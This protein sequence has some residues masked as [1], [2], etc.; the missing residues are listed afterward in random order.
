[1]LRPQTWYLALAAILVLIVPFFGIGSL[2][3][4]V[5]L[6]LSLVAMVVA[7]PLYG[8]RKLQA[9]VCLLSMACLVVWSILLGINASTETLK[10]YHALPLFA[11][12]CVFM[13]RKGILHDEKVVRAL[14]RIR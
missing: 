1:M 3:Q 14:D 2:P 4:I 11:I 12:L 9:L 10:W 13:A 6:A 8:N 7:I 5:L